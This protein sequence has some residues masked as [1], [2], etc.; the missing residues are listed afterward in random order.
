[1]SRRTK[2]WRSGLGHACPA[3]SST[4]PSSSCR[5]RPRTGNSASP[6][7]RAVTPS[8]WMA[9]LATPCDSCSRT[10]NAAYMAPVLRRACRRVSFGGREAAPRHHAPSSL[11]HGAQHRT[12]KTIDGDCK[13]RR[14]AHV[15]GA[16]Q[17][18]ARRAQHRRHHVETTVAGADSV[19]RR[20]GGT[21]QCHDGMVK[22]RRQAWRRA[23]VVFVSRQVLGRRPRAS[24]AQRAQ[25]AR[26]CVRRPVLG[27]CQRTGEVFVACTGQRDA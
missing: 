14:R 24:A 4:S 26:G 22:G 1:M 19:E 10:A 12:R 18:P 21:P 8:A 15:G 27:P 20:C 6:A 9:L 7:R 2:A 5:R 13:T 3:S 17:R 11:P 16:Q 23:A 25:R